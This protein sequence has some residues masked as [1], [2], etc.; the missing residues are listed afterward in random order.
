MPDRSLCDTHYAR[1]GV[2]H[3]FGTAWSYVLKLGSY[4]LLSKERVTVEFE[5]ATPSR[6]AVHG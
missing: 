1:D 2:E 5:D 6:I 3:Q 4:T